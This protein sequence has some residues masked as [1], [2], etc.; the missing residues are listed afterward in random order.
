MRNPAS[1]VG[2]TARQLGLER[3]PTVGPRLSILDALG[4]LM[5]EPSQLL[6]T[7]DEGRPAVL[8]RAD[9]ERFLPS[10]ATSLARYERI[11]RVERVRVED[12]VLG[13]ARTVAAGASLGATVAQLR[14]ADWRPIV[15]LD[16]GAPSGV[17]TTQSILGALYPE[18]PA[19]VV[20]PVRT[21]GKPAA[22]DE[23]W[24]NIRPKVRSNG[25]SDGAF[26]RRWYGSISGFALP[27]VPEAERRRQAYDDAIAGRGDSIAED[28]V[29]LAS[30][31][32]GGARW[33][34][35]RVGR[36]RRHLWWLKTPSALPEPGESSSLITW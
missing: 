16:G 8:T 1:T 15:V 28:L 31:A 6:L 33:L 9:L 25:S 32:A 12:A 36:N 29:W 23:A 26:R 21:D 7:S 5:A 34:L 30:G 17:Y 13:P 3:P 10:P 19:G 18:A 2:L 24:F 20:N 27:L 14:E 22:S 4:L 11:S 35:R